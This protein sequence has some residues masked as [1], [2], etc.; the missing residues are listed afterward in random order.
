[1]LRELD[2]SVA[3]LMLPF[4]FRFYGVQ[5]DSA[6]TS[7]NGVIGFAESTA[8]FEND[9]GGVNMRS[10]VMAFWDDLATRERGV[11]VATLGSSPNR[12]FVVTWNDAF[13]LGLASTHLTFSVVLNEGSDVIDVLYGSMSGGGASSAGQNATIG[14]ANVG[15]YALDCCNQPCVTS[16]T[17]RRYVPVLR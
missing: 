8:N 12:Q 10:A 2:D 15:E 16:N 5:T 3:A 1:V 4:P 11:C 14:L 9:C 6:W 13:V 17:G 7:S